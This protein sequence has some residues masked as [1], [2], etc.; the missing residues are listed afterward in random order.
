MWRDDDWIVVHD[1]ARPC[2]DRAS[3]SRLQRELADDAVGGMLA[4]PVVSALKR[5]DDCGR[6]LA[7]SRAKDCGRRRRRRCSGT[8]CCAM[9]SRGPAPISPSTK[10]RRS[11][12]SAHAAVG[13]GQRQQSEDQLS[14]RPDARRG[15]PGCRAWSQ[16][17]TYLATTIT[18]T[19]NDSIV[20]QLVEYIRDSG[21][22]AAFRSAVGSARPHRARD[23]PR[24]G[25]GA[26]AAGARARARD[27]APA[28]AHAAAL[29]RRPAAPGDRDG[30]ALRPSRQAAGD[31]GLAQGPRALGAGDRGRQAL[32]PR[33]RRRR[34]R[35]VRVARRD[36]RAAGAGHRR[37]RA[38][39]A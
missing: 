27:R 3:L 11:R 17:V 37:M 12:R 30:A 2:V 33:R 25:L 26:A 19:W 23:P 31:D 20:P 4:I 5:A 14:R 24:R 18:R 21:E 39:S 35:G 10:R 1:A 38:A 29:L 22:V 6:S 8:A 32:R 7:P 16:D 15:H 36:R 28:R 9:R 34:L 13:R